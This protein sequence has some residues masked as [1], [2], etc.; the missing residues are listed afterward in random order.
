MDQKKMFFDV[1]L[2]ERDD[3]ININN[4][5]DDDGIGGLGGGGGGIDAEIYEK[6]SIFAY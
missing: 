6:F 4:N 3:N 5:N 2:L 1:N